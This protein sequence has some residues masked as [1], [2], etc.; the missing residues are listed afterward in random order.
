[1]G[2]DARITTLAAHQ[3]ILELAKQH[4]CEVWFDV[5]VNTD[6]P[7]MSS[8][9]AALPSYVAAIDKIAAGARHHVVVF[10]LNA[11]N[12]QQRRA[13]SNAQAIMVGERLGLPVVTS[14]NG[15]QP[16][17]QNDNGW[18][19]GLLFLNP[20]HVWLQ[21][22]GYVTQ[23]FSRNYEPLLVAS[24]VQN[25]GGLD[26]AAARSED[27]KTIVLQVANLKGDA[28]PAKIALRQ[29]S[30]SRSSF[31][32]EQLTASFDAVNTAE[33]HDNVQPTRGER[34]LATTDGWIAHT[35][36]PHSFSVLRFE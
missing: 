24:E 20:A 34:P 28:Q 1:N 32:F 33:H 27:G 15:L 25:P 7:A 11:N 16:D 29:F 26:V 31:K 6:G 30:P 10:E 9:V 5:H 17:G 3:K 35:F 19:Q 22:P 12:H 4:N 23:M 18:D 8:S 14:A 2:S 21:P 36:P 13:L